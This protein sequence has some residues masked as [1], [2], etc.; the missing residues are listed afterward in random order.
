MAA[1]HAAP[2][3]D[4]QPAG[5]LQSGVLMAFTAAIAMWC[6][7]WVAH[8]PGVDL[9][10]AV[11]FPLLLITQVAVIGH[12]AA[13]VP[14]NQ[15]I[16]AATMGGI[17][18]AL[19]NLMLLGSKIVE[20]PQ[21][22][23]QMAEARNQFQPNALLVIAGFIAVSVALGAVAGALG[24]FINLCRTAPTARDQLARFGVITAIAY[25]PLV[26]VGGAVTSTN[27]GMA[28]PDAVRSY[29]AVSILFP[30]SLMAGEWGEPRIFLEH[31][32]RL[33]GTLVG[34]TTLVCLIMTLR[35]DRRGWVK[36]TAAA[37]F[38]LVCVQG[39][40]GA[41]RV[42]E[43]LE[44]LAVAHGVSGQIVFGTAVALAVILTRAFRSP[45][46]RT[47]AS[48]GRGTTIALLIALFI[49]LSLGAT[50]RHL[51]SDHALWTHAAFA[52]VVVGLGHIVGATLRRDPDQTGLSRLRA[53]TGTVLVVAVTLQFVLGFVTWWQVATAD[54]PHA[55]PTADQ[56]AVAPPIDAIEAIITTMHQTIGAG[57]LAASVAAAVLVRTPA[58]RT[59]ATGELRASA[60][61]PQPA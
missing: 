35:V 20:Q 2:Q 51:Q 45:A 31:T 55:N 23:A 33:F 18:A 16:P 39:A 10:Q 28:V 6:L 34:L 21:T 54:T 15:C 50:S 40:L 60:D 14:Q 7:W 22:T 19:I 37:V 49:Q 38:V 56:L 42:G 11:T 36:L 59:A 43:N 17:G 30:I 5:I 47:L 58:L 53:R 44:I 27:S 24:R 12:L 4:E 29:G 8:L 26:V 25:I 57:I 52:I 46:H 13:R 9:P 1:T 32:H 3:I 61:A 48:R 41:L